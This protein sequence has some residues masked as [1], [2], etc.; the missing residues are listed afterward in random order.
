MLNELDKELE[1]SGLKFCRY[2]DDCN[3]YVKSEKAANRVMR[4]I[5]K[6]IEVDLKLK[7]NQDKSSVDRPWNLKFLG[8]TFCYS[9]RKEKY[10]ILI[11]KKSIKKFKA[12]LKELTSRSNGMS[13]KTRL[14]KLKLAIQGWTHY[15]SI[16]SMGATAIELDGWV[17]RRIRMIIWKT[18]KSI[19]CRYANLIQLGADRHQAWKFVNWRKGYWEKSYNRMLHETLSTRYLNNLGLVSIKEIYSR[20]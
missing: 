1:K 11:H 6:F 4:S 2:A 5:T 10:V 19:R 20:C 15:F 18:W 9:K 12:K 13:M 7:V 14:L 17:R 8:F 16:S 3:I